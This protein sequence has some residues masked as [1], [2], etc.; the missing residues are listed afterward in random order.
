MSSQS[1]FKKQQKDS[2]ISPH[3]LDENNKSKDAPKTQDEY[4]DSMPDEDDEENEEETDSQDNQVRDI[5]QQSQILKNMNL[6]KKVNELCSSNSNSNSF[7]SFFIPYF[8]SMMKYAKKGKPFTYEDMKKDKIDIKRNEYYNLIR[9]NDN[10]INLLL[11]SENLYFKYKYSDSIYNDLLKKRQLY[12]LNV[13]NSNN[14]NTE[15]FLKD[16]YKDVYINENIKKNINSINKAKITV[17]NDNENLK[18]KINSM[19]GEMNMDL[20]KTVF[21]NKNY[22][23]LSQIIYVILI[24]YYLYLAFF[25]SSFIFSNFNEL[26]KKVF[27]LYNI[28][29]LTILIFLPTY[30]FR[31]VFSHIIFPFYIFILNN[32][33]LKPLPKQK[34][35]DNI[36]IN[37]YNY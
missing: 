19:E 31:F 36:N 3:I 10:R 5:K 25:V 1:D 24:L 35:F 13:S 17:I 15:Q 4:I 23:Y 30:I 7:S 37:E 22:D 18:Q 29:Y 9:R 2:K 34:G 21:N 6:S 14:K 26:F 11:Q 20:E 8:N 32:T 12:I 28:L 33:V 27:T 16:I